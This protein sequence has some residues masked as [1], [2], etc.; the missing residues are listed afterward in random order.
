MILAIDPA[1]SHGQKSD[2]TGIIAAGITNE[3]IGVVLEDLS[4]KAPPSVWIKRAIQAYHRLK[5]DRIVAE[6]NMGGALVEQLLHTF[7]RSVSYKAVRATRG[8]ALRAEQIAALYE[9]GKVWHAT[10]FRDLEE[11]LCSYVPGQTTKSPDRLDALVWAL[12]DLMLN[13]PSVKRV[14]GG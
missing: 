4:L 2:E 8:K 13:S 14:W 3:E 10:Y 6:V 9:Q 12:S 7:D 5:A 11:Q 1:V